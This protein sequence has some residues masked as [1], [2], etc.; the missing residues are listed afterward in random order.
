MDEVGNVRDSFSQLFY[1][2]G[3]FDEGVFSV[4]VE[5]SHQDFW[6]GDFEPGCDDLGCLVVKELGCVGK[7]DVWET[8]NWDWGELWNNSE[9]VGAIGL[10]DG[11]I[12]FG[13]SQ[14]GSE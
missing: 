1:K 6:V 14:V 5:D 8:T 9:G 2:N 12:G 3:T 11:P 7:V 10:N 13:D 4:V